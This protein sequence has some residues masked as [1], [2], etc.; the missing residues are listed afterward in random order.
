MKVGISNATFRAYKG[1]VLQ[2]K[3]T[4]L[5]ERSTFGSFLSGSRA[6]IDFTCRWGSEMKTRPMTWNG[7]TQGLLANHEACRLLASPTGVPR[8]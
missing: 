3:I 5:S 8:S 7:T 1:F 4:P 2:N 6:R